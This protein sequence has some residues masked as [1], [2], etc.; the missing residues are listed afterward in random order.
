ML[1]RPA[2]LVLDEPTAGLDPQSRRDLWALVTRYK[3]EGTAVL[4]TTHYMDEAE[5]LSDRV[6]IIND[7]RVLAIDSVDSLR[8]AHKLEFKA[9]FQSS[10]GEGTHHLRRHEPRAERAAE[11]SGCRGVHNRKGQ[12]GGRISG[13]DRR[14]HSR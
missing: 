13:A 7:G 5:A 12:P 9:T 8:N 6:G 4:L 14:G 2:L 10:D 11:R 3:T 1:T